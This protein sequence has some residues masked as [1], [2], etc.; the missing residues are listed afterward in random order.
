MSP[1]PEALKALNIALD[2]RRR[3]SDLANDTELAQHLGVSPKTLSFWRNGRWTKGDTALVT[4]LTN[5]QA[6]E[7]VNV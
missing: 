6:T 2:R 1:T 5:H 3:L 7:P 4:V